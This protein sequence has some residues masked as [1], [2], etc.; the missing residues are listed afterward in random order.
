VC[1][2]IPQG[3][4]LGPLLFNLFVNDLPTV[5]DSAV[6]FLLFADDA[7]IF[8]P[9]ESLSDAVNLQSNL[10]KLVNWSKQNYL[11]LNINKCS[12]ITFTRLHKP[13]L[14]N[15]SIDHTLLTRGN[16]IRNIGTLLEYNMS[17]SSHINLFINKAFKMFDSFIETQ[18]ILKT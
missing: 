15:Y 13:F 9:I 11:P 14:F 2:G 5:L 3:S 6:D 1:S 4:H 7:K 8:S 18:K 12:I 17:F 10:D 16:S